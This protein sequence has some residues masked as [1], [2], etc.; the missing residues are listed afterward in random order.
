MCFMNEFAH[1]FCQKINKMVF[2]VQNNKYLNARYVDKNM[3]RVISGFPVQR[4]HLGKTI[5]DIRNHGDYHVNMFESLLLVLWDNLGFWK[6]K[7]ILMVWLKISWWCPSSKIVYSWQISI[8][9]H[10]WVVLDYRLARKTFTRLLKKAL[11]V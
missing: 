4:Y 3:M 11:F 6:S 10:F 7:N 9:I 1:L 5:I 2:N 8:S